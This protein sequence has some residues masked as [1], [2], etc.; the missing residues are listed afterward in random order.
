MHKYFRAV[1][2]SAFLALFIV[3]VPRASERPSKARVHADDLFLT[4]TECM[5]CHNSLTTP[6]GEDVSIGSDWRGS[7]M[8]NSSRDPYWQGSVRREIMD[9]PTA[10][11]EIEAECSICH[12]PM[13]AT[14]A[15]ANSRTGEIFAHL[16][17]GRSSDPAARLAGDGVS[18][19]MCHQIT[20]QKLGTPDSFTGGYVEIG[21]AHV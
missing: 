20:D 4:S 21:R 2:V 10:Q 11:K 18:C 8:A 12:M 6:S 15:K 1:L 5:A 19:T 3:C 7:M 9:H 14:L 17:V 16:P 13:A